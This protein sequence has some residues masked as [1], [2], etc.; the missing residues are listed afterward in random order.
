MKFLVADNFTGLHGEGDEDNRSELY[1]KR[2]KDILPGEDMEMVTMP[3]FDKHMDHLE[4]LVQSLQ[5]TY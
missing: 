1:S 5:E 3:Y 2:A 4:T